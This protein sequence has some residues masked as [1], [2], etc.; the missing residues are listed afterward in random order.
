MVGL[1]PE[2]FQRQQ[3]VHYLIPSII[4]FLIIWLCLVLISIWKSTFWSLVIW[5]LFKTYLNLQYHCLILQ[6]LHGIGLKQFEPL[7][8]DL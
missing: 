5:Y 2:A 4:W 7:K 1:L 6:A 3:K 8:D